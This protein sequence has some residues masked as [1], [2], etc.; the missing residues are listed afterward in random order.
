MH[1]Y[2]DAPPSRGWPAAHARTIDAQTK[3]LDAL[4]RSLPFSIFM[5]TLLGN[6]LPHYVPR[7]VLDQLREMA[8]QYPALAVVGAAVLL[9]GGAK[10]PPPADPR[11]RL[12]WELWARWAPSQWDRWGGLKMPGKIEPALPPAG[13]E[14][15]PV[16]VE[17][18]MPPTL[19]RGEQVTRPDRDPPAD[20]GSS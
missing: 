3:R 17:V 4:E 7:E 18:E 5:A 20:G 14:L 8:T 6:G 15:A 10:I 19:R 11:M 1:D 16:E 13:V 12:L 9:L 2:P